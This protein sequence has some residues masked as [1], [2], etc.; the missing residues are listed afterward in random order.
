MNR[1]KD[2]KPPLRM[3]TLLSSTQ[4]EQYAKKLARG[5][6][7]ISGQISEKLL[8]RLA[9]NEALL[10]EVHNLLTESAKDN[11]RISPAAEWLLDNFYLIEEQ[12]YIGNKHLPKKYS[13]GLPHLEKGNSK[14]LPRVY[15]IAVEII[16][17]SDGRVD[18]YSL[19]NFIQAYQ[20]VSVLK[21]GELW[22][23]PI[24]L[25]LAIIE[26]LRR[27]AVQIAI[28]R[29]NKNQAD[30]WAD[31]MITTVEKEPK[32]LVLVI[33]E[34]AKSGPRL[35]SSF[36]AELTRR[37]QGTGSYMSFG[38]SWIEQRLAEQNLTADELIYQENQKQA[39]DQVSISNSIAGLRF[40]G[41][42]DWK[43]FV[44]SMSRVEAILKK[45]TAYSLM[46]FQTRD[47]YRHSI[48]EIAKLNSLS[49][50]TVA[51][52]ATE[53]T[54][55]SIFQDDDTQYR[56]HVGY[57]LIGNG[58]SELREKLNIRSTASDR[59]NAIF[60]Q[61]A[62]F[63]Y[64]L[65]NL[66]LTV[67]LAWLLYVL[68]SQKPMPWWLNVSLGFVC[69]FSASQ[70]AVN[71]INWLSTL[72]VKP[73]LLPRMD[74]S[75]FIPSEFTTL[76]VIPA[77]FDNLLQLESLVEGLEIRFLANR[78]KNLFYALLTDFRDAGEEILLGEDE[79]LSSAQQKIELLNKKYAQEGNDVFYIFH[80]RRQ[81]NNSD[82]IWMGYERKRG[83]L[84]DLN[85]LLRG[86]SKDKF[87]LICGN[88]SQL[89]GVKFVV[90]LD[91]DTQLPKDSAWKI[92]GNLA[93]PLNRPF[94]DQNKGRVTEGYTILQP[95]VAASLP[96]SDSSS[97]KKMNSS[98][99]GLDPYT[100]A[101]SDV[102]QDLFAEGSF[103]GK[104]IYEVDMFERVLK[105]T[106]PEN[107]ILSHDLL[108]GSYTR[109]GL[110]SDVQL[111]EEYPAKYIDDLKRRSRWVRGDW[112]VAAWLLPWIP[113]P[114]NK[115]Q[116]NALNTLGKWKIA[117]N[118]RRSI[119][120]IALVLLLFFSL[121]YASKWVLLFI[122]PGIIIL[123][124]TTGL[125]WEILNKPEDIGMW[126]HFRLTIRFS[127]N[128]LYQ[129]LLDF[130]VLPQTAFVNLRAIFRAHWRVLI[131]HRKLLQ[132]N[133]ASN[134][135]DLDY[136]L[137]QTFVR[138]WFEP[139]LAVSLMV[140]FLLWR[141]PQPYVLSALLALW[142]VSPFVCWL[143][144]LP[145]PRHTS[146]LNQEQLS[147]LRKAARRTWYFFETF[148][149]LEDN[150]LPPDNYQEA[151]VKR[152]A[153]RTSPTNIGLSLLG[154]LAALDLG[155]LTA[156]Q[157]LE[158]TANTITTM[159]SMERYKGHF[160]NWYDTKTLSPLIPK[161]IST[162]DSGNLAGHLL[163][164]KQELYAFSNAKLV[165]PQLFEGLNDTA[166]VLADMMP[167]KKPIENL[168]EQA[169]S[170]AEMQPIAPTTIIRA[171]EK[172]INDAEKII[173]GGEIHPLL[174]SFHNL[175]KASID[176]VGKWAGWLFIGECPKRFESWIQ[177]ISFVPTYAELTQ[178]EQYF[179]N[180][181]G[182]D[183]ADLSEEEHQWLAH[184][185]KTLAEAVKW[186]K[187]K[188]SVADALSQQCQLLSELDF[189]FLFDETQ[190]LLSIG[191]HT[192]DQRKDSGSYDLLA[193]E[194]R[195]TVFVA[196]S[197][198]KLPQESWFALG[199]QLTNPG[200]SPILLSWSGSMFEYLMPLLVMPA[201]DN[202]LLNQ[203]DRT[204]VKKQIE[205]GHK[206]SVP[207]GVSESGYN[208]FDASLNY[209]YKAFGVPGLGLKRG[210]GED[211][212]IAPYASAMALMVYPKESCK[213]LE[214]LTQMNFS[215]DYGF[216]EAID[217]TASRLPPGQRYSIIRSFMSHHQGMSLLAFD[218]LLMNRPMQRRF[219]EEIHFKSVLLLL[220]ERI[221]HAT[222]FYSPSVHVSGSS[223]LANI[224]TPLRI[225][226][227]PDTPF[228]EVQLLS[229]GRYHV[230]VTNSGGGYSRWK[231]IAVNRWREDTT[232][233]NWGVFCFVQDLD[234]GNYWSS[235]FQPSG[236][237]AEKY[238]VAFSQ[239]RADIRRKDFE[240]ETH[241][242]IVVSSED[243]VEL[244]RVHLTNRSRR[245]R[246]IE[247]TSYAEIVIDNPA[248]DDSHQ[249]FSK[250]FIQ[251]EI[252]RDRQAIICHRRSRSDGESHPWVFHILKINNVKNAVT[253]FETDRGKFIGRNK[254]IEQAQ[255][256]ASGGQLSNSEGAVLDPIVSV[257]HKLYLD[258]YQSISVDVV[259]GI[260][261]SRHA[262]LG[263]V[264]KYQDRPMT[265]R[266]FELAWTH[267]QVVLRQINA[268][269]GDAQ[270]Y[271][272]LASA[273][274]Y[275]NPDLR[276]DSGTIKKNRRSQSGLWSYGISGDL[277]IVLL[278]IADQSNITL[279]KQVVQAHA[280]WRLKGLKVD[281]V[282]WNED[283]GGYRQTLQNQIL[284][285]AMHSVPDIRDQQGGIF[286]KS[287]DQVSTEDRILFESV[288][289][290]IISDGWGSLE[291]QAVRRRRLPA[292]VPN[293]SPRKF[294]PTAFTSL[295]APTDL[296]FFNGSGGF[297]SDGKEYVIITSAT[298]R[299]P[300]PW[301]NVLANEQFGT[302]VSE[303]GQSY[304]WFENAHEFRL[305]P[306]NNDQVCD[307]GGETFY[308]R[309]EESGK[310]WSPVSLPSAGKFL[311]VTR[312]GFGYSKF[313]Y[314][315][316]GLE[317]EMTIFVDET[318]SIKFFVLKLI[319]R[320]R[321]PRIVSVT[322]FVEWVLG[323]LR[324]KN[325]MH[326]ATEVDPL[327]GA[328]IARNAY[329]I[330][331]SGYT[332]FFD[333]DDP[334]R[335]FTC[336][337]IEF[338][339]R[340]SSLKS[341]E[342]LN[343]SKLSGRAGFGIDPC[344]A[345]Q[346]TVE[347]QEDDEKE[348]VF[349]LGAARDGESA[350]A[351]ARRFKGITI[352][353]D[354][355]Q[356]VIAK[357]SEILS[358]IQ[359]NTPDQ[360]LNILANGWLNYQ[361]LAC[362]VF[363]RS[364]FYQ[365]GGAFGFRDQL[366][367]ILSLFYC[368]PDLARRQI[369]LHAS[370]QFPEGDVQHWWHPPSGKG[371]R[372]MCS[373]DLLWLPFSVAAYC[374]ITGDNSVL[375][376]LVPFI[377]GRPLN[378]GEESSY[379]LPVRSDKTSPLYDHC[380]K[381]IRKSLRLG[382][383][384]LPLMG[385]GDW[386]D[387]MDKVGIA[388]EGESVWLGF[389]LFDIL[390]NFGRLS[391]IKNDSGFENY[392]RQ[393][394]LAL[395]ANL[396]ANAWDGEWFLRAFYDDGTPSGSNRSS[397]CKIDSIAQSWAVL[398][399]A[400]S[401]DRISL[402]MESA[403]NHLVSNNLSLI[404]LFEPP[405]DKSDKNPGYIKGYVPGVRE[406]GGQYT[407]GAIWL[408]MAF[409]Q[410]VDKRRTWE[411]FNMVN[412]I[413]HSS[414]TASIDVYQVEPYVMAGDIYTELSH[415]GKGGWTWYTGA[416]SWMYKLILE[417]ILG[418][419]KKGKAVELNPCIPEK[420]EKYSISFRFGKA[421]YEFEIA[422]QDGL[423]EEIIYINGIKQI[424]HTIALDNE[425]GIF[426]I[427]VI[428]PLKLN[429]PAVRQ[430][431]DAS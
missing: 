415:A 113:G 83:K 407:H 58:L 222:E 1:Y 424:G 56:R 298:N 103:I 294:Y 249:A 46:D 122:I 216:F 178:F 230:M 423:P 204:S 272:R 260:G 176:E 192:D 305:S 211:L 332:A 318:E 196:I 158:R 153:H 397:E 65:A 36:V 225:I 347:L 252:L 275:A 203:T 162:V 256:L 170:F 12:I 413:A 268:S 295:E 60:T 172:L 393:N 175:C 400:A 78:H 136:G 30:Y 47:A 418:F 366:Q 352:A 240:I 94:Y 198:G 189:D 105:F 112:Q 80:R 85:N 145:A 273:I 229:N 71:I 327:S 258:P 242:E 69:F 126:H 143:I 86:K 247:I 35:T 363:A 274:V 45:E 10:L 341:P 98:D 187:D 290:L 118:L 138:M 20:E 396:E 414:N 362:R 5:H 100:K 410:M 160:F 101:I 236:T 202:T 91:A 24:M 124:D 243:D 270:L 67:P 390:K 430:E 282:I 207:W 183:H 13:L 333:T 244:R 171:L 411:L 417:L 416:A 159:R 26:N 152:I 52:V 95:R 199:R 283:R 31:Q 37:L 89:A 408:I 167:G 193:S 288:A 213:N 251:T 120:P 303:A 92:I 104:G 394:A 206:R 365:S 3:D 313:Q 137:Y 190:K 395:R 380:V 319:N 68:P 84:H 9:D 146:L 356:K 141:F 161:Y 169:A 27:L 59:I 231:E 212:V 48:E 293:F 218:Y 164:L 208:S 194:S 8:K 228:P 81:W 402:A 302:V 62:L 355:L 63:F 322:G 312:H 233:D 197:Q 271:G 177:R 133:P 140:Y 349:R 2:E 166:K 50:E 369:L 155:Y 219:E 232:C 276:A 73:K 129:H 42:T 188:I 386:N 343:K 99:H 144:S 337:R 181:M 156:S 329:S 358:T 427:K 4:M 263:L 422:Q 325:Y 385:S 33:A 148:V 361:S 354:A 384:G 200:T 14:G 377:D 64:L 75:K 54:Q 330:D 210:L 259:L 19:S 214:L 77:L 186:A 346:V 348:I 147:F 253:S 179:L 340:N 6:Q 191:F 379:D 106:M 182:N 280:Y 72:I 180:E 289:R 392:C 265:D 154:N 41:T 279:V 108:E 353:Q 168:A 235:G 139:L 286:I 25:R 262:C 245:R 248:A 431:I 328:L 401:P 185:K 421:L 311:Y 32:N 335:T 281:L 22:A 420:W 205:Y 38:L 429:K 174:K 217:Y 336:D 34:M 267:S 372:T 345:L 406:N 284:S 151:P 221:P 277:P 261:E 87:K 428:L 368:R 195:L 300:A 338:I 40:L 53:L 287:V 125:V 173:S 157:L 234:T 43:A 111:L 79:L 326:V 107:R 331:F 376:E 93:H 339:G 350:I 370:R 7:T 264:E 405:F 388:G 130:L 321:R 114:N 237:P 299:T 70:A 309:D 102:Y 292:T 117:D 49:E 97:Y 44:E 297:S 285:L 389:F 23:I 88:I 134:G 39:A 127:K 226:D 323:D 360:S 308:I 246:H 123:P 254:R 391:K 291:E 209:Q 315:E 296:Q 426:E 223:V 215:G 66:I 109:C 374:R 320:S 238:E 128:K 82:N 96:R 382:K 121:L 367:D 135:D 116:K 55:K 344:A 269:E 334:Q 239:G 21:L 375:D 425:P 359:V 324:A 250:L 316:E 351:L 149:G 307:Q 119:V 163:V 150:W 220:Q 132:W 90:T 357:W 224:D 16:S 17:H 373:D 115:F 241:T 398:S 11:E 364:G 227:T 29:I 342:A 381:A 419:T 409:A 165:S 404:Q 266:A 28:D 306:W 18:L 201:Y 399:G 257:R 314:H 412:P 142:F 301:C 110:V 387:G 61:N 255:A 76:V 57:Y 131:S 317:S 278:K 304:S 378:A 403:Y 310:F 184:F 15:D 371:V 51:A 383:H 74:F